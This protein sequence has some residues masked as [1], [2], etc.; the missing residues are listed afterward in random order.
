MTA[1]AE[2]RMTVN[3]LQVVLGAIGHPVLWGLL[4]I[5]GN[6]LWIMRDHEELTRND[7]AV[8]YFIHGAATAVFLALL[9][10]RLVIAWMELDIARTEAR[11][12]R[13]V[14]ADA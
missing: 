3:V 10:G 11:Y 14:N 6:P 7:L 13:D 2:R 9:V 5:F 8:D 12:L 4:A 1:V